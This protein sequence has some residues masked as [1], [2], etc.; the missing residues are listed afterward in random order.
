MARRVYI[1]LLIIGILI[2][3]V[4]IWYLQAQFEQDVQAI[5]MDLHAQAMIALTQTA[6]AR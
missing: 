5:Q 1:G 2:F 3:I 4:W 6:L